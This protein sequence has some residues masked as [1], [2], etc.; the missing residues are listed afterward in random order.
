MD[1][2]QLDK[3]DPTI[4]ELKAMVKVTKD[5]TATDLE[6]KGQLD[7]V[8]T[9]R[10]ALKTARV[11]IKKTGKKLREEA[12][13]YQKA[14]IAKEKELVAIIEPEEDRLE[15]IEEEAKNLAIMKERLEKLPTRLFRLNAIADGI[16][17]GDEDLL[18]MDASEFENYYNRRVADKNNLDRIKAEEE[19]AKKLA[20]IEA[21][22][23]KIRAEQDKRE[24]ELR[25]EREKIDA[26][27]REIDKQKEIKEAE[28]R[29][30]VEAEARIKRAD[31]E[32]ARSAEN[33]RLEA[34]RLARANTE[35]LAK[36]QA[37]KVFLKSHGWTNATKDSFKVEETA[38][39]YVLYKKLGV[40][41]K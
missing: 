23:A 34:E 39:G 41:S 21:E 7:I 35:R 6:D 2:K 19:Q 29:A 20:E 31:E 32:K 4:A 18:Q 14:V 3:F 38:E 16:K 1:E 12:L 17:I 15:A 30:R 33:S 11:K 36:T 37:Y 10:I 27:R 13:A 28:E 26:E 24:A 40:F 25:A 22:H 5:I 8:R 9:N